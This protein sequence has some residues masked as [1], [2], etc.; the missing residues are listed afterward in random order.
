MAQAFKLFFNQLTLRQAILVDSLKTFLVVTPHVYTI[1]S[2]QSMRT[3]MAE[4]TS[5]LK[6]SPNYGKFNEMSLIKETLASMGINSAA[7]FVELFKAIKAS[8]DK[9]YSLAKIKF[10]KEKKEK[11][12]IFHSHD[13]VIG[14]NTQRTIAIRSK[15]G[16]TPVKF[17]ELKGA[18]SATTNKEVNNLKLEYSWETGCDYYEARPIL[19]SSWIDLD[20]AHQVATCICDKQD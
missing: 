19:Y 6:D 11:K 2:A 10:G 3:F 13:S 18:M 20:P 5:F 9:S 16:K 1:S 12:H 17:Y 8:S 7:D 15:Y 4:F 14:L